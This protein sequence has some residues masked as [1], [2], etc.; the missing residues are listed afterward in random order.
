MFYK[1]LHCEKLHKSCTL[2]AYVPFLSL[3]SLSRHDRQSITNACRC[4]DL[5]QVTRHFTPLHFTPINGLKFSQQ[6][7]KPCKVMKRKGSTGETDERPRSKKTGASQEPHT[8]KAS[9]LELLLRNKGTPISATA[10]IKR[11]NIIEI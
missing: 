10:S 11:I 9:P 3:A 7:Q 1:Y 4:R 6:Y 5:K 2:F 8:H